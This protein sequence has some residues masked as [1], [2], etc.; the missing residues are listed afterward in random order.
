M[1][2]FPHPLHQRSVVSPQKPFRL[3]YFMGGADYAVSEGLGCLGQ[4]ETFPRRGSRD[5]SIRDGLDRI[6]G[7]DGYKCP[8]VVPRHLQGFLEHVD[9][10]K[11]AYPVVDQDQII[12]LGILYRPE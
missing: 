3:C 5:N 7:R 12:V 1:D 10:D 4:P 9:R 2:I 8:I 6:F 11:R